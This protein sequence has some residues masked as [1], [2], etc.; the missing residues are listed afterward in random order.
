MIH[1]PS[2]SD[3]KIVFKSVVSVNPESDHRKTSA[4][5]TN[6]ILNVIQDGVVFGGEYFSRR[7]IL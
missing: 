7:P 2:Q 1:N 5:L 6:N 4:D 3:G